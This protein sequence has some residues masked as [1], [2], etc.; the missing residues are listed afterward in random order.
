M[1][2]PARGSARLL[3]VRLCCV[4]G[5]GQARLPPVGT[6]CCV[7]GGG[8]GTVHLLLTP[9]GP[10]HSSWGSRAGFV[11]RLS[12]RQVGGGAVGGE[13][14]DNQLQQVKEAEGFAKC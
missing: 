9:P 14:G 6:V 11:Q 10:P 8:T 2:E 5:A 12:D 3:Q 4:N 13:G 7:G 1:W